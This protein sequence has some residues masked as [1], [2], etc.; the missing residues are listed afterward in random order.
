MNDLIIF[1]KSELAPLMTTGNFLYAIATTIYLIKRSKRVLK[2]D[3]LMLDF[4]KDYTS[5]VRVAK[6]V[7]SIV[8]EISS[9]MA[10]MSSK[11]DNMFEM[12]L[13]V[14]SLMPIPASQKKDFIELATRMRK[15]NELLGSNIDKIIKFMQDNIEMITEENTEALDDILNI[16]A[17]S[18]VI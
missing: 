3:S 5:V 14:L 18:D 10:S 15:D 6:K 7:S 11:I 9:G 1:L 4:S 17:R 16:E 13:L 8:P 12:I 2:V